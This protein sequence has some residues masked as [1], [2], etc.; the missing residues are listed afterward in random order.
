MALIKWSPE[1]SLF[2]SMSSWLS[3]FFS[4]EGDWSMPVVRGM[5]VPAVNV[6]ESNDNYTLELAAPGFQKDNF[7]VE[8]KNGYL[9][10]SGEMK[11]EKKDEKKSKYTRCE[12][13]Y[14]SFSRSFALPDDVDETRISA[15]YS[16]GIL[17]VVLPK[18]EAKATE[19]SKSIAIE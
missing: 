6:T 14:G 16:D 17:H 4:D 1:T 15:R 19:A 3:D 8:I 18:N 13:R 10:I 9:T 5:S 11:E 7:R 2:P 12:F